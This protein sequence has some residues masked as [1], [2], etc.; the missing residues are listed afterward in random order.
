MSVTNLNGQ[1]LP[2]TST[3]FLSYNIAFKRTP[4]HLFITSSP[5]D[6]HNTGAER[7]RTRSGYHI[8]QKFKASMLL[9]SF[10]AC[11]GQLHFHFMNIIGPIRISWF[12]DIGIQRVIGTEHNSTA[13]ASQ[14]SL[15]FA[16][17]ILTCSRKT[18]HDTSNI[19]VK[20]ALHVAMTQFR[21]Q[22]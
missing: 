13:A 8:L 17:E 16:S 11:Y 3:A 9:L 21:I 19:T 1:K 14:Q 12:L 22:A 7:G 2:K 5:T 18:L 6:T 15:S 4:S 10:V 20:H